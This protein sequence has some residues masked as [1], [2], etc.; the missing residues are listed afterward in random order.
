MKCGSRM[1]CWRSYPPQ[2]RE[3]LLLWVA[4]VVA[5]LLGAG[6]AGTSTRFGEKSDDA[7]VP[8]WV[9]HIPRSRTHFVGVGSARVEGDLGGAQERARAKALRHIAE[10]IQVSVVADVALHE[11]SVDRDNVV[12]DTSILSEQIRMSAEAA[13]EGWEVKATWNSPG[14]YFWCQVVLSRAQ[15]RSQLAKHINNAIAIA[16]DAMSAASTGTL[17][18]RIL[19]LCRAHSVMR[20]FLGVPMRVRLGGKQVVLNNEVP[21]RL[22]DLLSRVEVRPNVD[23]LAFAATAVVPDSLG[24]FVF[25]DGELDR[26]ISIAWYVSGDRADIEPLPRRADG[27]WPVRVR[28]LPS[29]AGLV[30]VTGALDPGLPECDLLRAGG[31]VLSSGSFTLRREKPVVLLETPNRFGRLL[32]EELSN[33]S[34]C[35]MASAS[36][37]IDYMLSATCRPEGNGTLVMGIHRAQ[38][39]LDLEF[40]TSGGAAILDLHKS[41]ATGDG[42]SLARARENAEKLAVDVAVRAIEGIF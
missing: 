38:V 4:V 7:D 41:V 9:A 13:L 1:A 3:Q 25:L 10:Q 8:S 27:L 28:P 37:T 40:H 33:R 5:G 42:E 2:Q 11:K 22:G 12:H 20:D 19:G 39:R 26:S 34:V 36:S 31:K 14:G 17:R 35:S 21:L 23:A 32:V 16:C 29:S 24:V 18:S 6:C 30:T 15:Y